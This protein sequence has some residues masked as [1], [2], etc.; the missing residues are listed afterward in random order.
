[1]TSATYSVSTR[2]KITSCLL[3]DQAYATAYFCLPLWR[4]EREQWVHSAAIKHIALLAGRQ[5]RSG[6]TSCVDYTRFTPASLP[7]C[8]FS[9]ATACAPPRACART[10]N[11]SHYSTHTRERTTQHLSGIVKMGKSDVRHRAAGSSPCRATLP[12]HACFVLRGAGVFFLPR[13]LPADLRIS[14]SLL[15]DWTAHSAVVRQYLPY[16]R[17]ALWRAADTT[18]HMTLTAA[19]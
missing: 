9:R 4:A 8:D 2:L 14:L 18:P 1:M 17:R 6:P 12:C 7:F 10:F 19:T 3:L 15:L 16:F 13:C 5:A 11:I